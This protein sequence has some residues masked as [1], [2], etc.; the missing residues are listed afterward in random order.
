MKLDQSFTARLSLYIL[1]ATSILCI[2][3]LV[4]AE[5]FFV[6][7]LKKTVAKDAGEVL[8]LQIKDIEKILGEVENATENM[9][10]VVKEN[11]DN[12][13]F[14]F[15]IC[16]KTLE[17]NPYI[18]GVA[19]GFEPSYYPSKGKWFAPYAVITSEGKQVLY[20]CGNEAYDYFDQEWYSLPRSKKAKI[21]TDPYYSSAGLEYDLGQY[22]TTFSVPLSDED[23]NIFAVMQSDVSLQDITDKLSSLK[24][25]ENSYTMLLG[26]TGSFIS[27]PDSSVMSLATIFE[28]ANEIG[29]DDIT[30]LGL[31]MVSGKSGAT[32]IKG[33]NGKNY[34]AYGS[35]SNG[36]SMAIVCPYASVYDDIER[37]NALL[38]SVII[39][40]LIL[41]F[42]VI[43]KIVSRTTKPITEFVYSALTIGK[44]NFNARLPEIKTHDE[45]RRLHDSLEYM[46][47]SFNEYIKQLKLS[48]SSNERYESELNIANK[49][50]K[51]MLPYAFQKSEKFDIY[52]KLTPAKEVGGDLYDFLV[53]DNYLYIAIG[54]VSGKGVPAALYMAITRYAFNFIACLGFGVDDVMK[55][56]NKSFCEGNSLMMF[57]TMFI[58]KI[59]LDTYEMEI[60]NAGHN[61]IVVKDPDGNA[62]FLHSNSNLAIGLVDEFDFKK[63]VLQLEKGT[64]LL[65]YTDGVTE[66]EDIDK[67]QYGEDRLLEFVRNIP[68]NDSSEDVI[69]KLFSSVKD[70]TGENEQN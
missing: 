15:N 27:H 9:V 24:G 37:T 14:M 63:E 11:V 29:R 19:I 30:A 13:D 18:N 35:L 65:L 55:R 1:L 21:W 57:V 54:D 47:L 61:P 53:R 28:F 49:I 23:G 25:Y 51:Q 34:V 50:Q 44:G 67:N 33:R 62:R 2:G 70:F 41:L 3:G 5:F 17:C 26:R 45:L 16:Q 4:Y 42:L 59:N 58:A 69:D 31:D 48:T 32:T 12:P 39:F 40:E 46:L 10:W 43:R 22:H 56:V 60:C 6:K 64:R 7:T 20:Q 66:A 8:N 52:A 68:E 38:F 36:W